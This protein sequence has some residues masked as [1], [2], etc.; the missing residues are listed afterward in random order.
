M[1]SR[2]SRATTPPAT[3]TAEKRMSLQDFIVGSNDT[4]RDAVAETE[5]TFVSIGRY[6]VGHSN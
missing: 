4:S 3:S 1:R 6:L 2:I 5:R